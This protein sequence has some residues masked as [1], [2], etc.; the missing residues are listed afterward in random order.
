MF[1][2]SSFLHI[3]FTSRF[4]VFVLLSVLNLLVRGISLWQVMPLLSSAGCFLFG[5]VH[6]DYASD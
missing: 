2:Y 5:G 4:Y 3:P 1:I 6:L